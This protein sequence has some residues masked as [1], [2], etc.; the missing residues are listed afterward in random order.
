RPI[1]L[2][3]LGGNA[4]AL[5]A[6]I[7]QAPLEHEPLMFQSLSLED[8]VSL[9]NSVDFLLF[10]SL[11]EGFGFP[12]LE[13]MACGVPVFCSNIPALQE[14]L[15]DAAISKPPGDIKGFVNALDSVIGDG[16]KRRALIEAGLRQSRKYS[17]ATAGQQIYETYTSLLK[18]P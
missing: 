3:W 10:P 1:Q 15:T 4:G 9:Y 17:W 5:R 18:G 14:V 12:P 8:V 16:R 7:D 13:A 11:Y 2:V 6:A